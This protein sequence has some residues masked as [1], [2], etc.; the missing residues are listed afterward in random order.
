MSIVF[1]VKNEPSALVK[2]LRPFQEDHFQK[3]IGELRSTYGKKHVQVLT[4]RAPGEL[5]TDGEIAWFPTKISELDRFA[6]KIERTRFLISSLV[7]NF[8]FS[9]THLI[10]NRSHSLIL[11][12]TLNVIGHARSHHQISD[13]TPN[14][15]TG[16]IPKVEYN[17]D[18]LETWRTVFTKLSSL[19][20][21]HA[22]KV[23][24]RTK[25]FP[26]RVPLNRGPTAVLAIV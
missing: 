18:E 26:P 16:P 19:F 9:L 3:A 8:T 7:A 1:Y 24:T 11:H 14:S 15:V 22:C 17:K 5:G 10:L 13:Y 4:R 25:P 23:K 20:E 21:T 6:S 2:A 12:D